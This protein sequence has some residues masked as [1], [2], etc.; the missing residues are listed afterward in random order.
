MKEFT[1]KVALVTGGSSGIGRATA[2]AFAKKGAKV[3]IA[4]R[5]VQESEQI[6]QLVKEC[7]SEAIFLQTD[8]THDTQVK[9][10]ISKTVEIYGRLDYAFN[11]AGTP[12]LLNPTIDD[13]EENWNHVIDTNVK[14]V[15]LSMKYE[16]HQMLNQG[17]G[18]IVNNAYIRG[19][20]GGRQDKTTTQAQHNSHFYCASKHAVIGLTKS[21]ALEYAQSGVRINAVCPGTIET[22]MVKQALS[23]ER[24]KNYAKQYPLGRLGQPE[25]IAEAV[26][27][28]CSEAASFVIGYSLVLDGGF[29]IQ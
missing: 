15:W 18:A 13:G 21:L 19:I 20:I 26:V 6:V 25:E 28:L 17:G 1:N 2:I 29:T 14:G 22:P 16:I 8:V 24:Q 11:N 9:N 27:W 3:V 12:G 7:G 10:L 4:S 23:K 5:R